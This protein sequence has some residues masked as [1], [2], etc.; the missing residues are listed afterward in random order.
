MFQLQTKISN[1]L[2]WKGKKKYFQQRRNGQRNFKTFGC[3][4]LCFY[5]QIIMNNY[6]LGRVVLSFFFTSIRLLFY[7]FLIFIHC[8][9]W[10]RTATSAKS[11][12][13]SWRMSQLCREFLF[14]FVFFPF[15]RLAFSVCAS[16]HDACSL[17]IMR[18]TGTSR[19]CCRRCDETKIHWAL[20]NVRFV[21]RRHIVQV[22]RV[23]SFPPDFSHLHHSTENRNKKKQ[24]ENSKSTHT[25]TLYVLLFL[26]FL[27]C[28][29]NG[30]SRRCRFNYKI[31][32][33]FVALNHVGSTLLVHFPFVEL[34]WKCE[35][36]AV[37]TTRC[38]TKSRMDAIGI[39]PSKCRTQNSKENS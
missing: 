27:L 35:S 20:A 1:F 33:I 10:A 22:N 6:C 39:R 8:F 7:F 11:T 18:A 4:C 14:S 36:V 34:K 21:W 2:S 5:T 15:F 23:R 24:T 9:S 13:K 25:L 30:T 32:F 12:E 26:D 3:F 38:N 17:K 16:A 28:Q 37:Q 19:R 29:Q 31:L